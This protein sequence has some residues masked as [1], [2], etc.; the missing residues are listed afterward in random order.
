MK[1]GEKIIIGGLFMQILFF[2][3]FFVTAIMFQIRGK[4][5]LASLGS[6]VPWRKHLFALYATSILIL[7]RSVFRVIEYI[8]GNAGYLLRHEVFL[9]VFDAVLMFAVMVVLNVSHPGDIAILLKNQR[10]ELPQEFEG[11]SDDSAE[12]GIANK[13][14][15]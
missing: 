8:Q 14:D 11:L 9:Y 12:R 6:S 4:E 5:Y 7:V 15:R 13:V 2:G 10:K 1:T 3:L